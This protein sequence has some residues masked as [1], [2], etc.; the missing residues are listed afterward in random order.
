MEIISCYGSVVGMETAQP[1]WGEYQG[2]EGG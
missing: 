1:G 2:G